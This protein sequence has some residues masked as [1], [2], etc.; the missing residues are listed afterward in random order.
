MKKFVLHAQ[1]AKDSELVCELTLCQVRLINDANYPWLILVPKVA[2]ISEVIQLS[3][4]QQRQLWQESALLSEVLTQLFTPDKL[5][6]A[7]L[8]NMV[9]QLHIHHI[10][11]YANDI[12]WPKPVWGQVPAKS[13]EQLQMAK[14]IEAVKQAILNKE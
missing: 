5:N 14:Q 10:V 2:D 7:A 12:S 6:I 8:G 13:Y 11:R 4:A 3:Q 9:A 1:L